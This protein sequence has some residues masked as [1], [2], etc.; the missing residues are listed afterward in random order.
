MPAPQWFIE[1]CKIESPAQRHQYRPMRPA[2]EMPST[3][4]EMIKDRLERIENSPWGKRRNTLNR[5]GFY[6]AQFVGK[7]FGANDLDAMLLGAAAKLDMPHR[8]VRRTID[9]ALGKG[10]R[11]SFR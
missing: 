9:S 3:V 10:L 8:E 7:G 1:R 6:L 11:R 4:A 2:D 5:E